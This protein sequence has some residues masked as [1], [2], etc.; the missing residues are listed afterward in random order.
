MARTPLVQWSRR[1]DLQHPPVE[2]ES[3]PSRC[4]R[5]PLEC[6]PIDPGQPDPLLHG[7]GLDR[8]AHL[9]S[10]RALDWRPPPDDHRIQSGAAWPSALGDVDDIH[11]LLT[12]RVLARLRLG[13]QLLDR[14]LPVQRLDHADPFVEASVQGAEVPFVD[15]P[16]QRTF[17]DPLHRVHGLD[18]LQDG[19][20]TRRP[21]QH[22]AAPQPPLGVDQP[23]LTQRLQD[24]RK[25]THGHQ[26]RGRNPLRR[27]GLPNLAPQEDHRPECILGCL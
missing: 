7:L 19:Q 5:Q 12:E 3:C 4:R 16:A 2:C 11:K 17:D 24:L 21:G 18:H 6:L 23:R 1:H 8:H 9:E 22:V 14:G 20:L 13:H 15:D 27:H 25:I 10:P 26:R